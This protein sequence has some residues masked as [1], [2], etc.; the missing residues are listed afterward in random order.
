[1]DDK[2]FLRLAIEQ[3]K[4]SKDLDGYFVGA[5]IVK[6]GLVISEAYGDENNENSHAEELAIRNARENLSGAEMYIT[7]EPCSSRPSGKLSCSDLII[8]SKIK[9][10]V[11]GVK[12]PQINVKCDGI[13]RLVNAGIEV[14]HLKE[15]EEA[16]KE[17]VP[18]L[19][20]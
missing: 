3:A 2:Y 9:R 18:S 8:A 20:E 11:Y 14:I 16:C 19:F 6:K 5:V 17:I 12:Y 1:M 7:M 13:E 4:M 10:V 15:L